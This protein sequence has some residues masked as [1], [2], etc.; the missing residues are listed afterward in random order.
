MTWTNVDPSS[1]P[2]WTN[3]ESP[4]D[5]GWSAA[6]DGT[7]SLWNRL[8]SVADADGGIDFI[9]IVAGSNAE[10]QWIVSGRNTPI[11][12]GAGGAETERNP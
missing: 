6:D 3:V 11:I 9:P 1:D 2:D 5:P 10:A 12:G 8:D 7:P 4:T